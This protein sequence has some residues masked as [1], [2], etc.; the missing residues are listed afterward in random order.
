MIRLRSAL[1][2]ILALSFA[3]P[4][5]GQRVFSDSDFE[6]LTPF[7]STMSQDN[8]R[9]CYPETTEEQV[10]SFSRIS[11]WGYRFA[12]HAGCPPTNPTCN[13]N[14]QFVRLRRTVDVAAPEARPADVFA[15]IA[16]H[17][18]DSCTSPREFGNFTAD[19]SLKRAAYGFN[20]RVRKRVCAFGASMTVAE[21]R[22]HVTTGY[23][24]QPDF[25]LTSFHQVSGEEGE[26]LGLFKGNIAEFIITAALGGLPALVP[27]VALEI[28]RHDLMSDLDGSNFL[29]AGINLAANVE[30]GTLGEISEIGTYRVDLHTVVEESGFRRQGDNVDIQ[31]LQDGYLPKFAETSVKQ[32]RKLE[33]DFLRSLSEV[34]PELYTVQPGDNLWDLTGERFG[35]PRL[36]L[37]IADYAGIRPGKLQVGDILKLPR[38]YELCQKLKP[39]NLF[40][41]DDQSLWAKAA[42]GEIPFDF[43]RVQHRSS[44]PDLIFPYEEL[45]VQAEPDG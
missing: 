13:P 10:R 6:V 4:A 29:A 37:L 31:F 30:Q 28:V 20:V 32:Y 44:D 39:N 35:D 34:G 21:G 40:V 23:N 26:F 45:V 8:F 19:I 43:D 5:H 16:A 14:T 7:A 41:R 27:M 22:A 12:D 25:K 33:I 17:S 9:K 3:A 42:A 38:W 1:P 36:F 15:S 11:Y 2:L 24:M 18:S